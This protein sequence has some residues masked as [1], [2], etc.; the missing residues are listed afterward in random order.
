MVET[1][2]AL[3]CVCILIMLRLANCDVTTSWSISHRDRF[4]WGG[5][6]YEIKRSIYIFTLSVINT[7]NDTTYIFILSL[8]KYSFHLISYY[9]FGK[10][11]REEFSSSHRTS[12]NTYSETPSPGGTKTLLSTDLETYNL[13]SGVAN[14]YLA[15]WC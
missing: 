5:G 10:D 8:T 9:S 1:G 11:T 15:S 12:Y 7:I 14:M 3:Q 6:F 2:I 4:V 13:T